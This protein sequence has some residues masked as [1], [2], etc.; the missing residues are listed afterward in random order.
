MMM[1]IKA[2]NILNNH[3][4]RVVIV[5]LLFL[6]KNLYIVNVIQKFFLFL[7]MLHCPMNVFIPGVVNQEGD[8]LGISQEQ[9]QHFKWTYL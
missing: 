4:K 1:P 3:I 7:F 2:C 5:I 6:F 8:M 9:G